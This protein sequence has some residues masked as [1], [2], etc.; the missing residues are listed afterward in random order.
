[1]RARTGLEVIL[2]FEFCFRDNK[3]FCDQ[4]RKLQSFKE[5][6]QTA[7]RHLSGGSAEFSRHIFLRRE[8]KMPKEK[9]RKRSRKNED[10]DLIRA[11]KDE[12]QMIRI[13]EIR[14]ATH[15]FCC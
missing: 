1:M 13:P 7:C 4:F 10:E 3:L 2:Y 6:E 8:K 9:K 12:S 15:G 5:F 11:D 14:Y